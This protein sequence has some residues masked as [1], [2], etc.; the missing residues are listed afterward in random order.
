M[1]IIELAKKCGFETHC[2]NS[3]D[4]DEVL[5]EDTIITDELQAFA[6]AIIEEC[7]KV[8]DEQKTVVNAKFCATAIRA[9]KEK[10]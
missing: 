3:I 2:F 7:A 5:S 4:G 10:Q 9:M 1:N 6:N 8:C